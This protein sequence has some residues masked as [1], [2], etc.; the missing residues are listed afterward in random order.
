MNTIETKLTMD[1]PTVIEQKLKELNDL[2]LNGR[3][4]DAFEKF[5]HE[6]VQMQENENPPVVGKNANRQREQ[7]FLN[8][9]EQ[10]R[11]ASVHS[12]AVGDNVSFVVWSYDY[13]HKQWGEKKYKQVSVQKWKDG[14][15]IH[16][17]FFYNG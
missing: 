14:K 3:M 11:D 2:I 10:F 15:I 6:D 4:M 16:E 7:E 13:S 12:V 9:I 5:Y 17:Q 1:G 8:N